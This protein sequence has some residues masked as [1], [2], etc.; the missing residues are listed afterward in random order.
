[1]TNP[2]LTL[3]PAVGNKYWYKIKGS[4]ELIECEIVEEDEYKDSTVYKSRGDNCWTFWPDGKAKIF[5]S[6]KEDYVAILVEDISTPLEE[7]MEL[8]DLR[9]KRE[10][11]MNRLKEL[12]A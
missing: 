2:F 6:G 8:K 12:G 11:M 9:A 5:S 4:D 3:P 7:S 1:M 10:G